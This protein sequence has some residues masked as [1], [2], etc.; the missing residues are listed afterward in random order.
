WVAE[1]AAGRGIAGRVRDVLPLARARGG[2][3]AVDERRGARELRL[4]PRILRRERRVGRHPV[5]VRRL[6][7]DGARDAGPR[8]VFALEPRHVMI[9]PL[10][11][12]DAV[13]AQ[14]RVGLGADQLLLL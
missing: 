13:A 7:V 12:S 6:V 14:A 5:L 8:R 9:G 11:G 1:L 10:A 4:R 3:T 2:P